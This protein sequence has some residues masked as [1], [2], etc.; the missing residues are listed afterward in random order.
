MVFFHVFERGVFKCKSQFTYLSAA[1]CEMSSHLGITFQCEISCENWIKTRSTTLAMGEWVNVAGRVLCIINSDTNSFL[2]YRDFPVQTN[3]IIAL[4][5]HKFE[6][7]W[8]MAWVVAS[9]ACTL[10]PNTFCF[11]AFNSRQ[12]CHKHVRRTQTSAIYYF[13]MQ[14]TEH[15]AQSWANPKVVVAGCCTRK[16]K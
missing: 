5:R 14:R 13:Y 12:W 9:R 1:S 2:R 3:Y 11:W 8:P 16:S 4:L 6:Q 15:T 10:S 7:S